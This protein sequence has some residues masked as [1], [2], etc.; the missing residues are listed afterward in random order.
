MRL[1]LDP[2]FALTFN[3]YLI[4]LARTSVELLHVRSMLRFEA[5]I[6]IPLVLVAHGELGEINGLY[7]P[8]PTGAPRSRG[9]STPTSS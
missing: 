7:F 2:C 9:E 1:D 3:P 8:G 4:V 5:K 6:R